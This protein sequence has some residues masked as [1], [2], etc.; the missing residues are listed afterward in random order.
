MAYN[1]KLIPISSIKNITKLNIAINQG[2]L[3]ENPDEIEYNHILEHLFI[4]FTKNKTKD[5]KEIQ[6]EF[7]NRGIIYS[8][9]TNRFHTGYVLTFHKKYTKYVVDIVLEIINNFML[10]KK[11]FTNELKSIIIEI[12][13]EQEGPY[14]KHLEELYKTIK[15]K[16]PKDNNILVVPK[17]DQPSVPIVVYF[18]VSFEF[19][20]K[21]SAIFFVLENI[22]TNNLSS[23]M[24]RLFRNKLGLTYYISMKSYES[25]YPSINHILIKTLLTNNKNTNIFISELKKYL[26]TIKI[27]EKEIEQSK[28]K[29]EMQKYNIQNCPNS[30]LN[31]NN[32]YMNFIL[33]DKNIETYTKFLDKCLSV[34]KKD[35]DSFIKK[36][37]DPE[38]MI[39]VS[40]K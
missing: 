29:I 32:Y 12:Q 13:K 8:G 37:M 23:Q 9:Y 22:L 38:K 19:Y 30:L 2:Y 20:S 33:I 28:K 40:N 14:Y 39:V 7:D 18:D 6:I 24:Y 36:Y 35:I 11:I 16:I 31:M 15:K 4:Y 25:I 3:N 17:K 10:E 1:Y 34:N 21:D 5:F 27:S 26:K